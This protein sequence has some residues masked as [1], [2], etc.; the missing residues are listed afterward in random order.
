MTLFRSHLGHEVLARLWLCSAVLLFQSLPGTTREGGPGCLLGRGGED[1]EQCLIA[2]GVEQRK[3]R[4][5]G[6]GH[7]VVCSAREGGGGP[8]SINNYFL[9]KSE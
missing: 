6:G 5:R 4:G 2:W 9:S 3:G 8:G 7:C 1:E